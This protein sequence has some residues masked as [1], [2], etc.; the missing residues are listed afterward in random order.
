MDAMRQAR[1]AGSDKQ[2]FDHHH[3]CDWRRRGA[4]RWE[5]TVAE[6][7]ARAPEHFSSHGWCDI[8][9][10]LRSSDTFVFKLRASMALRR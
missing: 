1:A 5:V 3:N 9:G 10:A 6:I 2:V 8:G 4:Q 7:G